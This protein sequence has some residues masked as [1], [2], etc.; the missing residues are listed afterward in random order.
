MRRLTYLAAAAVAVAGLAFIPLAGG[1]A[2][3]AAAA[4][5]PITASASTQTGNWA[6]YIDTA[7]AGVTMKFVAASFRVPAINCTKSLTCG[8]GGSV[9]PYSQAAFWVGIGG[10]GSHERTL[11]QGIALSVEIGVVHRRPD[12]PRN[13]T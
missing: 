11:E 3:S 9:F 6:G 5:A 4:P 10:Y 2:A 12:S 13:L 1:P 7:K 8:K